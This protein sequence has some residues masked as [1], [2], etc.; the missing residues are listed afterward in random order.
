MTKWVAESGSPGHIL[1]SRWP[2]NVVVENGLLRLVT[3]KE[4]RGGR[5]WTTGNI[6]TRDFRSKFGYFEARIRVNSAG[7]LNNA[8]WLMNP[9]RPDDVPGQFEID[10]VEAKYPNRAYFSVHSWSGEHSSISKL[11]TAPVDL[12]ADF[13]VYAMDWS[14]QRLIF[15]VDGI[16]RWR[17]ERSIDT[18]AYPIRLSTAVASFAGIIT[19]VLD[20]TSMDIDWVR[21]WQR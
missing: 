18:E 11:W 16:E 12:S 9:K 19:D 20:G 4:Q 5:E 3:R 2:E 21:V 6:S 17:A 15:Y 13:H 14:P 8:F 1:S 7:G 10:I